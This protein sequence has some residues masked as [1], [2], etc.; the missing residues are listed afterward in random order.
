M[1]DRLAAYD[2]TVRAEWARIAIEPR[3]GRENRVLLLGE[4]HVIAREFAFEL[5]T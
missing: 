4:S 5:R 1:A 3:R 2:Q